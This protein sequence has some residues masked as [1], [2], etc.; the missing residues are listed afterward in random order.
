MIALIILVILGVGI[1]GAKISLARRRAPV[2]ALIDGMRQT[3]NDFDGLDA[4]EINEAWDYLRTVRE[5]YYGK[6]RRIRTDEDRARV[7]WLDSTIANLKDRHALLG[8]QSG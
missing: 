5:T 4:P 6:P 7:A 1:A 3:P 8:E 2:M